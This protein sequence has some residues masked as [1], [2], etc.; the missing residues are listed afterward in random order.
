MI[1]YK[2]LVDYFENLATRNEDL[3]HQK[4]VQGRE[5][6]LEGDVFELF[7]DIG[8]FTSGTFTMLVETGS[9][10]FT[11]NNR[12]NAIDNADVAFSIVHPVLEK[13]RDDG[14][15]I[16][17]QCK[18]IAM[19][20]CRRMMYDDDNGHAVMQDFDLTNVRYMRLSGLPGNR[21]GIR[22]EFDVKGSMNPQ[23][24]LA[25]WSDI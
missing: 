25:K 5:C 10:I 23:I 1:D 22:C 24:T 16:L 6:F 19:E 18:A 3:Q 11:G 7:D 21:M 12:N 8:G 15:I 17:K 13:N 9:G 4:G 14:R 20:I 2:E